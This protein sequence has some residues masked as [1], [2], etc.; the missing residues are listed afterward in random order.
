VG[1]VERSVD[2]EAGSVGG[3]LEQYLVGLAYVNGLEVVAV[4][5]AAVRQ[6]VCGETLEPV[7]EL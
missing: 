3:E 2:I 5:D 7:T 4:H 1:R 6:L